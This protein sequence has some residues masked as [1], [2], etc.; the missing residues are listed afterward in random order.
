MIELP[1][2][3]IGLTFNKYFLTQMLAGTMIHSGEWAADIDLLAEVKIRAP[4]DYKVWNSLQDT[5]IFQYDS[6]NWVRED[7]IEAGAKV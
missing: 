7:D 3:N 4:Q 2:S 6:W 5:E 1:D